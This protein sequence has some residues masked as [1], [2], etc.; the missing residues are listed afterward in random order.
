MKDTEVIKIDGIQSKIYT[1]R[2]MQVMLDVDHAELYGV[3]TRVL[4]QAVKRNSERF[5]VSFCFQLAENDLE[6]LRSQSVISS[7]GGRR[8]LPYVFTEQGVA[9]LSAVLKSET[10]VRMSIQII[11]AF[12]VMRRFMLQNA[13]VFLEGS[14]EEVVRFFSNGDW[15][16]GAS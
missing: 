5:P 14:W 6:I 7:W 10:A 2:S 13:Q 12:V 3:E 11:N 4:N 1:I 9:M 8:Y 15:G 16:V